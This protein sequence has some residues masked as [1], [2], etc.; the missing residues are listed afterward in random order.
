M[1]QYIIEGGHRISGEIAID[2]AKNS[3]LPILSAAIITGGITVLNNC[4]DLS[5]VRNTLK[6]LDKLGCRTEFSNGRILVDSSQLTSSTIP[7]E[8][9]A[10][11]RSSITFLGAL[12]SRCGNVTTAHPGGCAALLPL[13]F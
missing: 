10:A 3:I 13:P 4:P 8:L 7:A 1:S 11:L 2:G 6:I 5:D 9:A 12:I